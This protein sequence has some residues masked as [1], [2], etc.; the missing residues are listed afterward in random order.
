MESCE[1][2]PPLNS[3]QLLCATNYSSSTTLKLLC[4]LMYYSSISPNYSVLQS[5]TPDKSSYSHPMCASAPMPSEWLLSSLQ[6]R[7]PRALCGLQSYTICNFF[8]IAKLK[9]FHQNH[10]VCWN[11]QVF[12]SVPLVTSLAAL[13]HYCPPG[14]FHW[15]RSGVWG[16]PGLTWLIL[17][18]TPLEYGTIFRNITYL[19]L[20]LLLQSFSS[21]SISYSVLK[22][23]PPAL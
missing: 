19:L 17:F 3:K 11:Y 14:P 9:R 22:G 1:V 6:E 8:H 18:I 15:V 12:Q 16:W 10:P 21:T 7:L 5:T 13:Q 23:T 4:T 20:D 2:Q